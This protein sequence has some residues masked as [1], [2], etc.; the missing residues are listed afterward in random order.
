MKNDVK[1]AIILIKN[2]ELSGQAVSGELEEIAMGDDGFKR[3]KM[4]SKMGLKKS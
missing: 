3:G 4:A 2:L 1:F